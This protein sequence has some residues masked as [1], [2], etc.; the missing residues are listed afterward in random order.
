MSDQRNEV[1]QG[2]QGFDR[3]IEA[4]K[5]EMAAQGLSQMKLA[6]KLGWGQT[7]MSQILNDTKAYKGA[8]PKKIAQLKQW[9]AQQ[10]EQRSLLGHGPGAPEYWEGPTAKRIKRALSVAHA[11]RQGGMI[12]GASGIGKTTVLRHYAQKYPHVHLVTMSPAKRGLTSALQAVCKTLQLKPANHGA[13]A[14]ELVLI[15]FLSGTDALLIIDEAHHLSFD[16]IQ[17]LSIIADEAKVALVF[18]GEPALE[19]KLDAN[20]RVGTRFKA[21]E[22]ILDPSPRDIQEQMD[23]WGLDDEEQREFLLE[24]VEQYPGGPRLVDSVLTLARSAATTS[25][26]DLTL[27]HLKDAAATVSKYRAKGGEA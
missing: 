14:A 10:A 5:A 24:L 26:K 11:L 12:A 21:R 9:L 18:A 8:T 4:V 2:T 22:V 6:K 19:A 17:N 25:N 20:R 16:A 13:T 7:V 15:E 23:H 3:V 27:K 1:E